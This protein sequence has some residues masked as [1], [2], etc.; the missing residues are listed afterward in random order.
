MWIPPNP[1]LIH[2]SQTAELNLFQ[3][4]SLLQT[5]FHMAFVHA[6]PMIITIALLV[7]KS[8]PFS[9]VEKLAGSNSNQVLPALH[10]ASSSDHWSDAY[11]SHA[12]SELLNSD[13]VFALGNILKRPVE[14]Y[15]KEDTNLEP[16]DRG[17][18]L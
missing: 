18:K 12:H 10:G 6:D 11:L 3:F 13:K 1:S 4:P 2:V 7:V 9:P 5:L 8:D 16:L 15:G 17:I 14:C